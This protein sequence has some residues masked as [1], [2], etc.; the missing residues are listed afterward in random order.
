MLPDPDA[1]RFLILA[2]ILGYAALANCGLA[3][4]MEP[5]RG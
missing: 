3:M 2:T 4:L 5:H 1:A